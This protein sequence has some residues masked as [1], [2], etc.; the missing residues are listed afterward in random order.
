M[1]DAGMYK[2]VQP[3]PSAF[4][5][6]FST[7]FIQINEAIA[8]FLP[9][10]EQAAEIGKVAELALSAQKNR[11][12]EELQNYY[13]FHFKAPGKVPF[14]EAVKKSVAEANQL[15]N[16]LISL[17]SDD[18]QKA[19]I[20]ALEEVEEKSII[21]F[22]TLATFQEKYIESL[23]RDIVAKSG[24]VKW[25]EQVVDT[26]IEPEQKSDDASAVR[27]RVRQSEHK[28]ESVDEDHEEHEQTEY[29]YKLRERGKNLILRMHPKASAQCSEA[30]ELLMTKV[31][32]TAARLAT[33]PTDDNE[34][35]AKAAEKRAQEYL[36]KSLPKA[37]KEEK[38]AS[39]KYWADQIARLKKEIKNPDLKELADALFKKDHQRE[40]MRSDTYMVDAFFT[41]QILAVLTR[42]VRAQAAVPENQKKYS[43]AYDELKIIGSEID[44]VPLEH[45]SQFKKHIKRLID[46]R[47]SLE[48]LF[49]KEGDD[50]HLSRS[51]QAQ[52]K[53][54]VPRR[55]SIEAISSLTK[56]FEQFEES[57]QI[58]IQAAQERG[59]EFCLGSVYLENL[60]KYEPEDKREQFEKE[61]EDGLKAVFSDKKLLHDHVK[62]LYYKL[63]AY[64]RIN[65]LAENIPDSSTKTLFVE[66]EREKVQVISSRVGLKE[67]LAK[68]KVRTD[69]LK[70]SLSKQDDAEREPEPPKSESAK[71]RYERR[72]SIVNQSI[73]LPPGMG[74]NAV[75]LRSTSKHSVV[76]PGK[77]R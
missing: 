53:D 49:G 10:V 3:D 18:N 55:I 32:S 25:S 64:R 45:I 73:F 65:R 43:D 35:I 17:T 9:P 67:H 13:D 72:Y 4:D 24:H 44:N 40:L 33:D 76:K 48:G 5:K 74:S 57:L 14:E 62:M 66:S 36:E 69:V 6:Q 19:A 54:L 58:E 51:Y 52:L 37:Y 71:K 50:A 2:S 30:L 26:F 21:D 59:K 41:Q 16:R 34:R 47:V 39:D 31:Q 23:K 63:H 11:N 8:L 7:L 38:A 29:L 27:I 75:E 28:N 20:R 15:V 42:A 22:Q 68:L 60:A 77:K 61:G 70:Q 56:Q 1:K 12:L 46:Q